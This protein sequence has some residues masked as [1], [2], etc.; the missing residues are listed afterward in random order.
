MFTIARRR[1]AVPCLAT[2]TGTQN[3]LR[4]W[5]V[6]R[7]LQNS[8]I[9][10][11][12]WCRP[13]GEAPGGGE[14]PQASGQIGASFPGKGIIDGKL[15]H[16]RPAAE[17]RRQH[18]ALVA[19][20]APPPSTRSQ[21]RWP[22]TDANQELRDPALRFCTDRHA[23]A[24]QNWPDALN[25]FEHSAEKFPLYSLPQGAGLPQRQLS[26]FRP[27]GWGVSGSGI[28]DP[29]GCHQV[30]CRC[31]ESLPSVGLRMVIGPSRAGG[32]PR[33][34]WWFRRVRAG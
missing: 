32:L 1:L 20:S 17:L 13:L 16:C 27:V 33:L 10:P 29:A 2:T 7:S 31:E 34:W 12:L 11:R 26:N 28:G 25:L 9:S 4:S 14:D 18:A 30:C 15:N 21:A 19:S 23:Q 6:Q 8:S 24:G 22:E 5:R 3:P